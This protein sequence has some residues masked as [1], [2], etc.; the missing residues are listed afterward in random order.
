MKN[1]YPGPCR[2]CKKTVAAG[3]GNIMGEPGNWEFYHPECVP[4]HKPRA[5]A[6]AEVCQRSTCGWYRDQHKADGRCP[7]HY[8]R[9]RGGSWPTFL[10]Y[11]L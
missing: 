7:Y 9:L 2:W 1:R 5:G 6:G 4:E 3:E 8:K 10:E 11:D